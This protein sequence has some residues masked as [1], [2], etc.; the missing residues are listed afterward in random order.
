MA[1]DIQWTQSRKR[2]A[3]LTPWPRNPRQI[4]TPQAKRLLESVQEFGQVETLAV[5]PDGEV[6]NGHQRLNVLMQQYGPEYEVDVRVS[7]RPLSEKE[8]EKLTV[9]LHRGAT[10]EWDFDL[11]ANGFDVGELIEWGFEPGELG[12][13]SLEIL[14]KEESS[15]FA[16]GGQFGDFIEFAIVASR[17]EFDEI[18]AE[19]FDFCTSHNLQFRVR[20][21]A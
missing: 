14:E 3:D 9:Y 6:Y 13:A 7:S 5:G 20:A 19:L 2:L 21:A 15:E 11:L 10:G 8:R 16:E 17:L 12:F 4:K 18:R 1:S